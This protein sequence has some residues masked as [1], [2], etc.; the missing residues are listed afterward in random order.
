MLRRLRPPDFWQSVTGSLTWDER[1]PLQAARRELREETGLGEGL[2]IVD[3]VTSGWFPILPE[4]RYRYGCAR[5]NL[6][7]V[8]RVEVP[9]GATVELNPNEHSEY[10]W[11]PRELAARKANSHTNRDAILRFVPSAY[12]QE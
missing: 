10:L 5:E 12:M 3:C 7:H 2:E 11:L 1:F 9:E 6:E 4:W 8:F